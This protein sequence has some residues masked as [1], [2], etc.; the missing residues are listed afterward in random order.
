MMELHLNN[1][2]YRY[3]GADYYTLKGI[4]YTFVKGR[5]YLITGPN[6]AG[7]TTLLLVLS[8]LL[9]PAQGDVLLDGESI[10]G[11]ERYRRFFG[12]LFQNP[13]LML[14]NPTVYD[15]VTYSIK[16]ICKDFEKID[17]EVSKWLEFFELDR[18]ILNRPTH[19]LSYGYKKVVALIS[20]LIHRPRI[21]VLDEPHTNL[22]K[23]YFRKIKKVVKMNAIDGGINIIASHSI[24]AYRDVADY[25]IVL[26]NGMVKKIT[27]AR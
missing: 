21:L 9:K 25:L 7:K 14:F 5:T 16:Q 8:G 6:G 19:T 20:I 12:V 13:D 27:S 23:K 26:N 4:T 10:Y 15:E 18:D 24:S 1:V 11:K 3:P 17:K 22:S 2:Y